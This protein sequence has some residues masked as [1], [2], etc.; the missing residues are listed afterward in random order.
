MIKKVEKDGRKCPYCAEEIKAEAIVC[1]YCG[2]EL[3]PNT[4]I[5]SKAESPTRP[6][7]R[8]CPKC[9]APLVIRMATNGEHHGKKFYVCSNYPK[10]QVVLPADEETQITK[11]NFSKL[12]YRQK[13]AVTEYGYL[14]SPEDA[15]VVAKMLGNMAK[16]EA[17]L[18]FC[19]T[20]GKKVL[21]FEQ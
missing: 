5:S 10:C 2:K 17:I 9:R 19:K 13:F 3:S 12:T 18:A 15:E 21:S 11:D 20:N 8:L 14:L 1:R 4:I 6:N 16:D 7:N